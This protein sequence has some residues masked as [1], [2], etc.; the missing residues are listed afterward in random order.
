MRALP[1]LEVY[2]GM[3]IF[4]DPESR[5]RLRRTMSARAI[6]EVVS[7]HVAGRAL[8]TWPRA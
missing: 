4:C 8:E 7:V 2:C 3:E 6:F 5:L 1:E